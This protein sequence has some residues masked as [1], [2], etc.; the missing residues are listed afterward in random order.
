MSARTSAAWSANDGHAD[1]SSMEMPWT[2]WAPGEIDTDGLKR[3]TRLGAS[4]PRPNCT[5]SSMIWSRRRSVPVVST[6]NTMTRSAVR[7]AA[8]SASAGAAAGPDSTAAEP[9]ASAACG[10]AGSSPAPATSPPGP[11]PVSPAMVS[12]S[13]TAAADASPPVAL[14]RRPRPL[15]TTAAPTAA[16]PAPGASVAG[17][18]DAPGLAR[19]ERRSSWLV[20][21]V[22]R[23]R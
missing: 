19:S 16:S 9:T 1:R 13:P 23:P 21:T 3:Q 15:P 8:G 17:A 18:D 4:S 5:H 20:L 22:T 11:A 6:S 14:R 7:M 12:M 2:A 10:A